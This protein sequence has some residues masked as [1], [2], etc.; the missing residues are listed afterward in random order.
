MKMVVKRHVHFLVARGPDGPS[1]SGGLEGIREPK[2]VS[3]TAAS[4]ASLDAW[5]SR[6]SQSLVEST[7][8][9]NVGIHFP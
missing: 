6:S 3:H 1:C 4:Q 8:R 7:S 5:R 9:W 2:L